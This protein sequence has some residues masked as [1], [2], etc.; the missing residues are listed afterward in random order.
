MTGTNFSPILMCWIQGVMLMGCTALYQ[1]SLWVSGSMRTPPWTPPRR[2]QPCMSST[3]GSRSDPHLC[4]APTYPA[5]LWTGPIMSVPA[6]PTFYTDM[7][8]YK[9][10]D[11]HI[12]S[13]SVCG[14]AK[15]IPPFGFQHGHHLHVSTLDSP[16][17]HHSKPN[18]PE[19]EHLPGGSL[20]E[21]LL[22]LL[23]EACP[24]H[25]LAINS[26]SMDI[27]LAVGVHC[28]AQ[29][30][31]HRISSQLLKY[32]DLKHMIMIEGESSIHKN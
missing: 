7:L 31:E 10:V 22:L 27:V 24:L 14:C 11:K 1:G 2:S 21:P 4:T 32:R 28:L 17:N 23:W 29:P 30:V 13:S 9:P 12:T 19:G 25:A 18:H 6:D 3:S 26:G 5:L 20:P 15:C 16:A 8:K